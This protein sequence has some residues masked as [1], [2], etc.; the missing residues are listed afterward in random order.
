MPPRTSAFVRSERRGRARAECPVS[1]K[2]VLATPSRAALSGGLRGLEH[3]IRAAGRDHDHP[4][5][6]RS[7][8][9]PGGV[10][11]S[12]RDEDEAALRNRD[13]AVT[14]QTGDLAASH[15]ERL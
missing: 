4:Q 3:V 13:L 12:T 7:A 6:W 9:V 15:I 10:S 11:C 8:G 1:R 2:A 14:E 5:H